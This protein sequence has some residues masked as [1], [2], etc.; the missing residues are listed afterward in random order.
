L[1]FIFIL[2]NLKLCFI[3]GSSKNAECFLAE[4]HVMKYLRHV[5]VI[6]LYGVCTQT[7][8]F[9]TIHE[10][11]THGSLLYYLKGKALHIKFVSDL[12]QVGGFLRFPLPIKLTA[13]I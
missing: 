3:T 1:T 2:T 11:M 10:L 9:C 4:A 6:Q 13:T 7:E 5:N 12:R 8:P